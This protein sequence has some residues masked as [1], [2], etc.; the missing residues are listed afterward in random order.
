M[1]VGPGARASVLGRAST[2]G[3]AYCYNMCCIFF[4]VAPILVTHVFAWGI[5][6]E[7]QGTAVPSCAVPC[8]SV[9]WAPSAFAKV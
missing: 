6:W 1:Y 2:Y 3:I 8:M 5:P 7:C 9:C 4:K